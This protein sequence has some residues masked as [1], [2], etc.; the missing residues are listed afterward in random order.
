M[1]NVQNL[2]SILEDK[3]AENVIV[4]ELQQAFVD[5]M[6]IAT[7]SSNRQLMT[8]ADA[9]VVHAKQNGI[10]PIVDGTQPSDWV[11]V[12]VGDTL[13]HLFK[14]EARS[15]YNIEKMWGQQLEAQQVEA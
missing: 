4:L 3:K 10:I 2:V 6:I 5:H 13:V 7:A 11:V 1:I 15:Y 9:V 12:D 14:A 8:L